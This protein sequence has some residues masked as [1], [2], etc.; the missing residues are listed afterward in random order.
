[1]PNYS[2]TFISWSAL[3][4][5]E[6]CRQREYLNRKKARPAG[7]DIR[8]YVH[9][10]IAD[11]IVRHVLE[12][13]EDQVLGRMEELVDHYFA[14]YTTHEQDGGLADGVVRW[15]GRNDKEVTRNLVRNIVKGAEPYI[16]E[17]VIPF[18]YDVALRFK[19]CLY[20]PGL[21]GTP[22][23][24][25]LVGEMDYLVRHTDAGGPGKHLYYGIDLKGTTSNSY[26]NKTLGQ[27]I[28]YDLATALMVGQ[29]CE[30]WAFLQPMAEPP[31]V[32]VNVS[33]ED[34]RIMIQRIHR[35]CEFIW[36]GDWSPK[37]DTKGCTIC[38]VRHA[39]AK[40]TPVSLGFA[41]NRVSL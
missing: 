26:V 9:G 31:W 27:A 4:R 17:K 5:H 36:R 23:P 16:F 19:E 30:Q 12:H 18:D 37:D 15:R 32:P 10:T 2:H 20:L 41:R 25:F 40:Y 11:R 1:M 35:M 38:E 21:D 29:P 24:V 13:E 8:N 33:P 22:R 14:L 28:F 34:R 3:R 7:T 6:E 39:C